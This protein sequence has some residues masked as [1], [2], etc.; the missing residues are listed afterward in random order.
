M[1]D[2]EWRCIFTKNKER[3]QKDDGEEKGEE[4]LYH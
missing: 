1:C 3:K 4:Y 2:V